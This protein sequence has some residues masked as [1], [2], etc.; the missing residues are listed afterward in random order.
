MPIPTL[1]SPAQ[2]RWRHIEL[3]LAIMFLRSLYKT[4]LSPVEALNELS[5][6]QP[7]RGDF[8]KDAS[9]HAK[10]G[11]PLHSYLEGR[12]P[13]NLVSPIRI[14]ET[15]GRLDDV[16]NGMEK[17]LQQQ[18]ATRKLLNKLYYPIFIMVGGISA[19]IFVISFVIPS[20]IGNI[21]FSKPPAIL[22]F[23]KAMQALIADYGLI[24]LGSLIAL[25][26]AG[27][28]KWHEDDK[29][30]E[31]FLSTINRIP[32]LGWATRWLWFSVW[33]K[34]VSIM[35]KADIVFTDIF[36]ITTNTLPP[37]LRGAITRITTQLHRGQTLTQAV[38]ATSDPDD[39]R[40]LL[41][42]HIVNAFRMTDRSGQGDT[43]FAIASETL[44]EPGVEMLENSIG[45]IK[46]VFMII[47]AAL[48]IIP[49]ALYLQSVSSIV[50]MAGR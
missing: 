8:W 4:G 2:Q 41:P 14:A 49:F 33:A 44:F 26:I 29:F 13:E 17:T 46:H 18:I 20:M 45:T 7:K 38:T 22:L 39:P 19:A 42:I 30:K 34:Y 43:Q 16:F 27:I 24:A 36:R 15:S 35:I 12:W 11:K 47:S 37:H 6:L 32:V 31:A 25:L 5:R 40:H 3:K 28:W 21:R 1:A 9:R 10:S 50:S 23:S 48:V